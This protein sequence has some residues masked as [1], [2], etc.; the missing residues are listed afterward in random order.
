MNKFAISTQALSVGFHSRKKQRILSSNLNLN[1]VSGQLTCL[2]GANGIGKSTLL[3]TL[4]GLQEPV[5]GT[6]FIQNHDTKKLPAAERAKLLS[7]VLPGTPP[8]GD[9]TARQVVQ[10]GRLPY[11]NWLGQLAESDHLVVEEALEQLDA[12]SLAERSIAALSDGE[13]QKILIARALAQDT[14]IVILD[15]PTAFLDWSNRI[16]L[17]MK[18]KKLAHDKKLAVLV[19]SHDLELVLNS[20]DQL[21]V[22]N[23]EGSIACGTTDEI[24][25]TGLLE[26]VFSTPYGSFSPGGF[27]SSGKVA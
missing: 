26:Q 24:I 23:S 6:I 21:W 13:R 8:F 17:L 1:L 5:A 12:I 11:S 9:L 20:A 18:L 15:E 19:S 10:L 22:M 2:V 16:I 7:I 14:G 25:K 4:A 3:R 27:I